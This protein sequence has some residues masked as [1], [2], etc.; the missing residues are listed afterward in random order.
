[1]DLKIAIVQMEILDGDKE[2]N[3]DNALNSLTFLS[4][5]KDKADIVVF[6]ELFTTGYDQIW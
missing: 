6:P 4:R 5:S 3:L 1:M 2:T